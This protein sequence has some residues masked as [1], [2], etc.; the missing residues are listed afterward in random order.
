MPAWAGHVDNLDHLAECVR[1]ADKEG[2]PELKAKLKARY[3]EQAAQLLKALSPRPPAG[4]AE[5]LKSPA[6]APL[7]AVPTAAK[8]FAE[9]EKER[10]R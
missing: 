1:L 2:D 5:H 7:R 9:F 4:L 6:L 3:G 8:A 10:K